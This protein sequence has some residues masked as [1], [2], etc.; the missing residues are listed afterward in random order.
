MAPGKRRDG[1]RLG[2]KL[3][4][5]LETWL[6]GWE[7]SRGILAYARLRR[8]FSGPAVPG[9]PDSPG[10]NPYLLFSLGLHLLAALLI[11]LLAAHA[12]PLAERPPISV[13]ILETKAQASI[14]AREQKPIRQ[15]RQRKTQKRPRPRPKSRPAPPKPQPA[16]PKPVEKPIFT[17]KAVP[18]VAT[19]QPQA[20]NPIPK[21]LPKEAMIPPRLS[22][23]SP[24]VS[25]PDKGLIPMPVKPFQAE[26]PPSGAPRETPRSL[27]APLPT[28]P[29][30][31]PTRIT[32]LPDPSARASAIP[33]ASIPTELSEA[34]LEGFQ[35]P[36]GPV[37]VPERF[38]KAGRPQTA[39]GAAVELIDTSDPDF[40]EYFQLIKRRVYAAWRYPQGV[41]GV[42]KV[43]VRFK[44]DRAGAARGVQVVRSTNP[45]INASA[46]KAMRRAS[47]FPPIPEKFRALVGQPLTLVFTVTIQ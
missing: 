20:H 42:H 16:P 44:L 26:S 38:L 29:G 30:E 11:Y 31:A 25:Q 28:P 32:P 17:P 8:R 45:A 12:V 4:G 13:R 9:L 33:Q 24:D 36:T 22:A 3:T 39:P 43:S 27:A 2:E 14:P 34:T 21:I 18:R 15:K 35:Q 10:L 6:T 37:V 1:I 41:R 47:P 40:T 46:V 7:Q 23:P 19:I 5:S